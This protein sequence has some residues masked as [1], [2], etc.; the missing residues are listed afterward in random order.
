MFSQNL[1]DHVRIK[2]LNTFSPLPLA[3][4]KHIKENRKRIAG[5]AEIKCVVM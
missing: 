3:I 5:P 4:W 2:I 1:T